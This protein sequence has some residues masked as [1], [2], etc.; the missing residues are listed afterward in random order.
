MSVPRQ[1]TALMDA[2]RNLTKH[3]AMPA[4]RRL[5]DLQSTI[6]LH[7]SRRERE[8]NQMRRMQEGRRGEER[9]R[10]EQDLDRLRTESEQWWAQAEAE[11][12]QLEARLEQLRLEMAE[13]PKKQERSLSDTIERHQ[14]EQV[15]GEAR[16][17]AEEETVNAR[18]VQ[19]LAAAQAELPR[20]C[21]QV[22]NLA[23]L[24]FT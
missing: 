7:P 13:H 3:R 16:D 1:P 5:Q 18:L 19:E 9:R 23:V 24:L 10:H 22:S 8:L 4:V 20:V 11:V 6:A 14:R 17:E 12:E 2:I 15:E 21:E